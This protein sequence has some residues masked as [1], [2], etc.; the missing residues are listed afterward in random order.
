MISKTAIA[1][2][3]M[4][5]FKERKDLDSI[6]D[7]RHRLFYT[8]YEISPNLYFSV[9]LNMWATWYDKYNSL[10]EQLNDIQ[11]RDSPS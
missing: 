6:D 10:V 11:N 5:G 4:L 1:Y 8:K 2:L 9:P 7:V 3:R